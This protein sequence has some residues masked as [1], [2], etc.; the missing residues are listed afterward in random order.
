[1]KLF[2]V[3]MARMLAIKTPDELS[4]LCGDIDRAFQSEKIKVDENELLYRL[5]NRLYSG[6]EGF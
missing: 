1:M 5:I 2:K 4:E 6:K 3:F